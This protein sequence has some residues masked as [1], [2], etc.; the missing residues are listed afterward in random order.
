MAMRHWPPDAVI[1]V[2]PVRPPRPLLRLLAPLAVPALLALVVYGGTWLL[3]T[4]PSGPEP[5][6]PAYPRIP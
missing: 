2:C 5:T 4:T 6:P 1:E 3:G